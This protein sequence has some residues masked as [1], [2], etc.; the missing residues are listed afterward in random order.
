MH[1]AYPR[2]CPYPHLSGTTK[3]LAPGAWQKQ[4]KEDVMA[5][6]ETMTWH[7]E[8]SRKSRRES[9][10]QPEELPWGLEEELFVTR[11]VIA[12][13]TGTPWATGRAL[14]FGAALLAAA[15]MLLQTAMSTRDAVMG[16]PK[17]K[18]SV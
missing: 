8:Q 12:N 18:Y 17:Q 13:T 4:T 10:S 16:T 5:N 11:P 7:V 14:V 9:R 3:P 1:H 2:E 6:V 15:V